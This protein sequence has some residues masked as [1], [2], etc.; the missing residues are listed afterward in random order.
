MVSCM[1]V[2]YLLD[3]HEMD[4]LLTALDSVKSS[5]FKEL[6]EETLSSQSQEAKVRAF[7][8]PKFDEVASRREHFALPTDE[9]INNAL[10]R[11]EEEAEEKPATQCVSIDGIGEICIPAFF[12]PLCPLP[13]DSDS[14]KSFGAQSKS[15]QML[16]YVG[17][18]SE[19]EAMPFGN[20]QSVI[21]GIHEC[22]GD[23][24]RL[25][26]VECT[27]TGSGEDATYSIVKTVEPFDGA[28]YC[29]TMDIESRNGVFRIQGFFAEAGTTGMRDAVVMATE[30]KG[31][32]LEEDQE[33][34][35]KGPYDVD[36]KRGI[37]MNRSE[38]PEYDD[39]FPWH[40]L[41]I[42]RQTARDIIA[43]N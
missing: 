28:Q 26:T 42:C 21:D 31:G 9:Q 16:L 18:S 43:G 11:L 35:S 30:G 36:F 8:A 22:L 23:N 41:S 38:D 34:W 4:E 6:M 24:Q 27:K 7:L 19:E 5:E 10:A 13:E 25:I 32:T 14:L 39:A 1:A 29:L 33:A 40:P 12:Q 37:P 17:P 15:A 20:P 3:G 2:E